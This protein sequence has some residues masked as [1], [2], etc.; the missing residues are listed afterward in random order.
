MGVPNDGTVMADADHLGS[1]LDTYTN[2]L[3]FFP[4]AEVTDVLQRSWP[5]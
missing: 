4:D 5:W 3:N 1:L 2:M